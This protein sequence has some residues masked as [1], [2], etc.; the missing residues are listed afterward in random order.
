[1][2][3]IEF[4]T[5]QRACILRI[6]IGFLKHKRLGWSKTLLR[7]WPEGYSAKPPKS[8]FPN[9]TSG[10]RRTP[11]PIAI[12][13][14]FARET[15]TLILCRGQCQTKR[16]WYIALHAPQMAHLS[17]WSQRLIKSEY[18]LTMRSMAQLSIIWGYIN[19]VLF[20]K[21]IITLWPLNNIRCSTPCERNREGIVLFMLMMKP[22]MMTSQTPL[23]MNITLLVGGFV[24]YFEGMS[25]TCLE[26]RQGSL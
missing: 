13:R 17:T 9:P 26:E 18:T 21:E 3:T 14:T 20:N 4:P 10:Q 25:S 5:I 11:E 7:N 19:S 22:S 6:N 1:M 8:L 24:W 12:S 16:N 15:K 2:S 23:P